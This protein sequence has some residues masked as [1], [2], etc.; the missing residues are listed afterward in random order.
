MST[1]F[2]HVGLPKTGT[3]YLQDRLW[4]NRDLALEHFDLL[5]PGDRIDSHFHA[6]AHLQP[7]R[8]LD[9]ANPDFAHVWPSMVAQMKAWPR[10]S[11]IS[12]EL[13]ATAGPVAIAKLLEDLD[14]ADEV[15]MVMTV[16]DLARQLPSVWQENVK[17][18][19]RA[20]FGD[21][22]ESVAAHDPQSGEP[23]DLPKEP[24]WVFQDYVR[25]LRDWSAAVG[26]ER[27]HVVTVPAPGTATDGDSLWDR[28][29]SVLGANATPLIEPPAR[30][31]KSLT[32]P[33]VEFLRRLNTRLQPTDVPW[34]RYEQIVKH[35]L[36]GQNLVT[37]T[38]AGAELVLPDEWRAW[39]AATSR[40]MIAAIADGGYDIVGTLGDLQVAPE[41]PG[42]VTEPTEDEVLEV[43]LNAIA[44]WVKD[45]DLPSQRLTVRNRAG[46]LVRKVR[47][48]AEA[49]RK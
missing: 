15:H 18:Q 14:F 46:N 17:N 39:A 16:R 31:N 33:Q 42:V 38:N 40:G 29:L 21:Y 7:E 1:V 36:I 4:R 10:T 5:Y 32:G 43:A 12:H 49:L 45:A 37:Q 3:T 48:R 47:R 34:R 25:I 28:F 9:W 44:T 26:P 6:S 19:R 20:T 23:T 41:S 30:A 24:F 27:V 22:L 13:Y 8:Y 11:L 2:V 35:R